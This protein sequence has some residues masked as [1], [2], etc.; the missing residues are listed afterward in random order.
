MYHVVMKIEDGNANEIAIDVTGIV[1]VLVT[2]IM[3][4]IAIAIETDVLV[5]VVMDADVGVVEAETVEV[6]AAVAVAVVTR[7]LRLPLARRRRAVPRLS[8]STTSS[9]MTRRSPTQAAL[10]SRLP[11]SAWPP[12]TPCGRTRRTAHRRLNLEGGSS[13]RAS[14]PAASA[15]GTTGRSARTPPSLRRW[16]SSMP[17]T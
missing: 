17:S 9:R 1:D 11:C 3:I 4:A 10:A 13:S 16:S 15:C 7:L 12:R 14:R 8:P 2:G 6:A 5:K